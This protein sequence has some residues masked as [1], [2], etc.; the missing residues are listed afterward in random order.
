MRIYSAATEKKQASTRNFL[1]LS[2]LLLQFCANAEKR[3]VF[4]CNYFV[5]ISNELILACILRRVCVFYGFSSWARF[6]WCWKGDKIWFR[7]LDFG[8]DCWI[9]GQMYLN[10]MS[11]VHSSHG[12]IWIFEFCL[13]FMLGVSVFW[14]KKGKKLK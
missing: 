6:L 1:L 7:L 8:V 3:S 5:W 10:L 2:F 9:F 11:K 4:A 13:V 14:L 12:K